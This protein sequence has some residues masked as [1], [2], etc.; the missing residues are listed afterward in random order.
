ML[1]DAFIWQN[2]WDQQEGLLTHASQ[3]E[4]REAAEAAEGGNLPLVVKL[5]KES[6]VGLGMSPF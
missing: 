3:A 5:L 6:M 1:G 2:I 4:S